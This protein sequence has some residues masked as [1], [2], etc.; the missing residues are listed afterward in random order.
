MSLGPSQGRSPELR[1]SAWI[2][3][4]SL[5]LVQY[6]AACPGGFLDVAPGLSESG[7]AP[8]GALPHKGPPACGHGLAPWPGDLEYHRC[9]GGRSVECCGTSGYLLTPPSLRPMCRAPGSQLRGQLVL[10]G[11]HLKGLPASG[12][13]R[14]A[15]LLCPC[16]DHNLDEQLCCT[17][18]KYHIPQVYLNMIL[19]IIQAPTVHSGKLTLKLK[20]GPLLIIVLFKEPLFSGSMLVF[21]SVRSCGRVRRRMTSSTLTQ[22]KAERIVNHL[23]DFRG[24]GHA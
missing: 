24:W 22:K 15:M 1:A 19:V 12:P 7:A 10:L 8:L 5:K 2:Q 23:V 4:R 21:R 13:P 3:H 18:G 20:R 14:S 9:P 17:P 16:P 11:S 6:H